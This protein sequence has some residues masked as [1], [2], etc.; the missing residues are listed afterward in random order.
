M[1]EDERQKKL[2]NALSIF[3]KD[4]YTPT[5]QGLLMSRVGSASLRVHVVEV[6]DRESAVV[7][8]SDLVAHVGRLLPPPSEL[9]LAFPRAM[10]LF[11]SGRCLYL[12]LVPGTRHCSFD[13]GVSASSFDALLASADPIL[14]TLND[15]LWDSNWSVHPSVCCDKLKPKSEQNIVHRHSL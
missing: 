7:V 12:L 1:Q 5:G 4:T 15:R 6:Q 13:V 11:S 8:A 2:K 14:S 10:L 9:L 3:D